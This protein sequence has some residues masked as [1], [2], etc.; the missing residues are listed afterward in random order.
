MYCIDCK[1]CIKVTPREVLFPTQ[2]TCR[3]YNYGTD[4]VTGEI[5]Y[6]LC[7]WIREDSR[8]K[9]CPKFEKKE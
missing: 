7:R 2:W 6:S 5:T 3:K 1:N 4:L 8:F 9:E